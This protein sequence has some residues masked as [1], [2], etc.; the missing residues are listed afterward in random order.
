MS[1][2]YSD[3]KAL[4]TYSAILRMVT[5]LVIYAAVIAVNFACRLEIHGKHLFFISIATLSFVLLN[6]ILLFLESRLLNGLIRILHVLLATYLVFILGGIEANSVVPAYLLIIIFTGILYTRTT[7][8]MTTAWSLLAYL[9]LVILQYKGII[10]TPLLATSR[11]RI[12]TSYYILHA[13]LNSLFLILGMFLAVA[14]LELIKKK[15]EVV[16]DFSEMMERRMREK[17]ATLERT[18]THLQRLM[19]SAREFAIISIDVDGKILSFSEGSKGIFG[20]KPAEIEGA[21][22]SCLKAE[23]DGDSFTRF[24]DKARETF[25]RDS[26]SIEQLSETRVRFVRKDGTTFLGDISL[27]PV[28]LEGKKPGFIVVIHDLTTKLEMERKIAESRHRYRG[29]IEALRDSLFT[30]DKEGNFL[31]ANKYF[32]E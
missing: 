12:P 16:R 1:T 22:I 19:N 27:S 5:T 2:D 4:F 9:T 11:G 8:Y 26:A 15:R 30:L 20:W 25:A 3:R 14:V 18:R 23:G 32:L 7:A 6:V 17:T 21:H 29:F 24:L 28:S 10:G 13:S 31:W